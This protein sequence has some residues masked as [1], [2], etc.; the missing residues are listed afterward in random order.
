MYKIR[1]WEFMIHSNVY[2]DILEDHYDPL[3]LPETRDIVR[4]LQLGLFCSLFDSNGDAI[5]AFDLW[6]ALHPSLNDEIIAVWRSIEPLVATVRKYRGTITF[7]MTSNPTEFVSRWEAFWNQKFIEEFST[8]QGAFLA[9]NKKLAEMDSSV[10]FRDEIRGILEQDPRLT[11]PV[12]DRS[13]SQTWS[14]LILKLA[15][16]ELDTPNYF[17]YRNPSPP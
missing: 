7:H 4:N 15:F 12:P 11:Q 2:L 9:L 16:R 13:P 8:A 5:N 17:R 14:D 3:N 10:T 6:L 1:L